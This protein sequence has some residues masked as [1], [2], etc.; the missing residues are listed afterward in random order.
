MALSRVVVPAGFVVMALIGA[1]VSPPVAMFLVAPLIGVGVGGMVALLNP[2][3][4]AELWA[5]RGALFTGT[6]AAAFVPFISGVAVV[7]NAGGI[8]ALGLLILGSCLAADRMVDLIEDP[9]TGDALRDERWM[10][11]VLPSLPTAALLQEWR[12]TRSVFGSRSGATERTRAARLREC[13]LEELARR[14]PA[15]VERWL[16]SGD[17]SSEPEIRPDRDV[18]G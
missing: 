5:R 6:T 12:S 7:G 1:L 18:A 9:P 16:R 4:P 3:F 8:V 10:R 15:A 11:A 2:A 17:W 13:I 14:D